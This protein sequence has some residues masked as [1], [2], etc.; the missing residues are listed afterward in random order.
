MSKRINQRHHDFMIKYMVSQLLNAGFSKIC[1]DIPGH[2]KP[3]PIKFQSSAYYPDVYAEKDMKKILVEVETD[4][5]INEDHT[6]FEWM[7]LNQYKKSNNAELIFV[8]PGI[9][10]QKLTLRAYELGIEDFMFVGV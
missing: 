7:A 2:K 3:I 5:S 8:A 10:R 4:D 6:E 9:S 1:A